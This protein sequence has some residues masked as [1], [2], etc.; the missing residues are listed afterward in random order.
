MFQKLIQGFELFH[1]QNSSASFDL[2][3]AEA[4]KVFNPNN[5]DNKVYPV[6]VTPLLPI[7]ISEH[8]TANITAE[9][10]QKML[11]SIQNDVRK[12]CVNILLAKLKVFLFNSVAKLHGMI[13]TSY[14]SATSFYLKS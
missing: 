1:T 10:F 12:K 7:Q 5:Y 6:E 3:N 14:T 9:I 13:R 2:M 4:Q 11:E 8:N